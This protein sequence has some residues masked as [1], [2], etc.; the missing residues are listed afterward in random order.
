MKIIV[1]K[2]LTDN[3][4]IVREIIN[5]LPQIKIL[6]LTGPL[7]SGKTTLINQ[8]AKDLKI[9]EK[10]T[11]PTFILWQKYRFKYKAKY[12]FLNHI[13]FYRIKPKDILKLNL[14]SEINK[15]ENIFFIEWGEKLKNYLKKH[16]KAYLQIYIM[17][18]KKK[19]IFILK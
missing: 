8:I 17:K 4:K 9:K 11:S 7:G 3:K 5:K 6:L 19:R 14:K 15:E 18:K 10:L 2:N 16:H 13:D 1:S 12:Y